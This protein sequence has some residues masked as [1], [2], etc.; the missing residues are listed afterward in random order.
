MKILKANLFL[1][2]ENKEVKQDQEWILEP[3]K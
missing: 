2:E 1:Q 3:D